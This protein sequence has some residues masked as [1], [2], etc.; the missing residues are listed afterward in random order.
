MKP[1]GVQTI[2]VKSENKL[3]L[4]GIDSTLPLVGAGLPRPYGQPRVQ[5][6]MGFTIIA[7]R[8]PNSA[9]AIFLF[10]NMLK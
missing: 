4:D 7:D 8:C 9:F 1:K 5:I 6:I 2:I 10:G 3:T